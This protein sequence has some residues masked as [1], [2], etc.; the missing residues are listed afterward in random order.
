[1]SVRDAL[2]GPPL[3]P[4]FSLTDHSSRPVT[5]KDFR[6]RFLLVYFGFTH[7]RVVCPRTGTA[8]QAI[9]PLY[10]SVDPQRDTPEVMRVFLESRFPA[11]LGLTGA[12]ENVEA[13][14]A[15]FRVFA[16]RKNDPLDADGYAVPHSATAFLLAP[17]GKYLAHFPDT[18]NRDEIVRRIRQHLESYGAS[19]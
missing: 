19:P 12:A 11:F 17:D 10:I 9:Q 4:A 8:A 5:E 18:L 15:E 7:C 1:M 3:A 16:E 14:K 13:A 6:G 2:V